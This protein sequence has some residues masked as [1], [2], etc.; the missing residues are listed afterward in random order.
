MAAPRFEWDHRKD[1]ENQRKHGIT[2]EEARTVFAD[3]YALL[4]DDPDHSGAEERFILLGLSAA[5]RMLVVVHTYRAPD[6]T[7]RIISARKASKPERRQY[8]ARW[9]R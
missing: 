7:I 2:F 3:E 5:V 4:L 1:A 9:H 6:D 8:D